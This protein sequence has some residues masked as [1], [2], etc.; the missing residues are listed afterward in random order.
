MNKHGFT[1]LELIIALGIITIVIGGIFLTLRPS[2]RRDLEN[3]SLTLQADLRYS[4]RRAIMEGQ[5][6]GIH[7]EPHYNR[8]SIITGAPERVIRTVYLQNGVNLVETSAPRLMFL[9]RGTA[10]AGFRIT[11]SNGDYWQRITATVSGGRIHIFDIT[12]DREW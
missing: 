4:Q 11:L 10:S 8:Y 6:I 7:F 2:T 1:L 12:Q 9:P 3:A 5:R